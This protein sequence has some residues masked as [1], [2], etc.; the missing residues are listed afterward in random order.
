MP[1]NSNHGLV[2]NTDGSTFAGTPEAHR[3]KT[4]GPAPLHI[5]VVED[6]GLI[7]QLNTE[8]LARSGYQV[9]AVSDGVAGWQAARS[10]RYHLMI[11]DNNMPRLSGLDLIKKLRSAHMNLPIIMASGSAEVPDPALGLAATLAKP[12]TK[13][14]LLQAVHDVLEPETVHAPA[15][16]DPGEATPPTAH[17]PKKAAARHLPPRPRR[18]MD[19]EVW[20]GLG[21]GIND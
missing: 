19:P 17:R 11:T 12:F 21:Y 9:D 15:P 10:K 4:A 20:D 3:Y 7:R 5:L 13:A 18:P 14:Q 1:R 2:M 16:A 8:S 6:D